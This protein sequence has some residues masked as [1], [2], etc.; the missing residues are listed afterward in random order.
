M[1]EFRNEQINSFT[2]G[3]KMKRRTV[4]G[5]FALM[6]TIP[7]YLYF[8]N[9]GTNVDHNTKRKVNVDGWLLHESDLK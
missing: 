5:I 9:E 3:D 6:G 2:L 1:Q 7:L 4:L 8:R